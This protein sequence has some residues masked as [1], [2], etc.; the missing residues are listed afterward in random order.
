MYRVGWMQEHGWRPGRVHRRNDFARDNSRLAHTCD[1]DT[2]TALQNHLYC[3]SKFFV[4]P[5][6]E[7]HN[8]FRLD[9]D[10]LSAFFDGV[11]GGFHNSVSQHFKFLILRPLLP[12]G[13]R[14]DNE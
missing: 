10:D 7:I 14:V 5:R 6:L 12:K 3:L 11:N 13:E 2:S 1:D 8:R 9:A 4:N